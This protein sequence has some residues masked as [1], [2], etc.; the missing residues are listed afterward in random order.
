MSSRRLLDPQI[1]PVVDA[2]TIAYTA[3]TLPGVRAR[4]AEGAQPPAPVAN[5]AMT[6]LRIAGP[7]S[8]PPVRMLIYSPTD[9]PGPHPL[10]LRLHGG[11][12]IV[13]SP[14]QDDPANRSIARLLGCVVVSVAY[15]L[16]PETPFPGAIED[17]YAA[18]VW[19]WSQAEALGVD[20]RRIA[21]SG[22]SAGGGLAAALALLSRDRGGPTIAFQSLVY[23]MLDDRTGSAAERPAQCGE[24]IWTRASNRF[25]WSAILGREPGGAGV[26]PYAAPARAERLDG[27]PPAFI[28]VGALDLFLDEDLDYALRLVRA[29]APVE[30]HVYPGAPHGF[31]AL[32]GLD[33]TQA[34]HRD[35]LGALRR[36]FASPPAGDAA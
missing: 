29:G 31:D 27:L 10:L 11:A 25:A 32:A 19:I 6:D 28:A 4:M 17:C 14:E 20:R 21:V 13:G 16:A 36:A 34:F 18:L 12:Y 1:S 26:S 30:L 3:E 7:P 22:R 9:T 2:L 35:Y 5:V 15:R 24:F 23:P 33:L 8:G